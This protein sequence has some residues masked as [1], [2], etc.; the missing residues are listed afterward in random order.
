MPAFSQSSRLRKGRF[1]QVGRIYMITS[2]TENRRP[3]F[4]DWPIAQLLIH[5]FKRAQE[6]GLASSMAWV[7]MP[8]HFHWLLEL[9]QGSLPS[10][11]KQVKA[12]SAVSINRATGN[13]GRLWQ[14]GFH[15]MALREMDDLEKLASYII[16]NPLRAGLVERVEDYPLWEAIW[17]N[18]AAS[19]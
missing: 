9:K 10:L 15:D 2:I 11:I 19:G 7:V 12:S 6:E 17:I 8:D 14:P 5:E 1:T 3:V 18:R 16:T 13:A 4:D